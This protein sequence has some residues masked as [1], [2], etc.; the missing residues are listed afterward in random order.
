[1]KMAVNMF[2][3]CDDLGKKWNICSN[4]TRKLLQVDGLWAWM[5]SILPSDNQEFKTWIVFCS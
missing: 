1:M 4:T 5:T 3:S 2:G